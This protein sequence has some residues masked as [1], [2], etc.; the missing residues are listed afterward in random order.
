MK[1]APFVLIAVA[2]TAAVLFAGR[3]ERD[4]AMACRH[5]APSAAACQQW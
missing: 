4:L 1:Y 5:H 2:I 3:T